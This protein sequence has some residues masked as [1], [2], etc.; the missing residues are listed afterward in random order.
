M[1]VLILRVVCSSHL[2]QIFWFLMSMAPINNKS[3]LG[4][5]KVVK[6]SN[7]QTMTA[8]AYSQDVFKQRRCSIKIKLQ[9]WRTSTK[10][11]W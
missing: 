2:R 1:Q 4:G 7:S 5:L 3:A 11:Q 10:S 9:R 6:K 8:K